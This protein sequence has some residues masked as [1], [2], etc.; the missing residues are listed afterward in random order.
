MKLQALRLSSSSSIVILFL[1]SASILP[2]V[3][4]FNAPDSHN[5]LQQ[6]TFQSETAADAEFNASC[7]AT[8]NYPCCCN[9]CPAIMCPSF[10][11]PNMPPTKLAEAH[12][13]NPDGSKVHQECCGDNCPQSNCKPPPLM[14]FNLTMQ[15]AAQILLTLILLTH[16]PGLLYVR[17]F[18]IALRGPLQAQVDNSSWISPAPAADAVPSCGHDQHPVMCLAYILSQVANI[19]TPVNKTIARWGNFTAASGKAECNE[20][21]WD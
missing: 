13:M 8:A 4:A 1:L 10:T 18:L 21:K 3:N 14:T 20:P 11:P 6:I 9:P 17:D 2:I 15:A 7:V 19:S 12:F 5:T 16:F